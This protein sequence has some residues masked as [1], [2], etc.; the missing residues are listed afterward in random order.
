MLC[1]L[2]GVV[3]RLAISVFIAFMFVER[4]S[5]E[6]CDNPAAQGRMLRSLSSCY[7]FQDRGLLPQGKDK[8]KKD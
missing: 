1:V 4:Y 6:N 5:Q 2:L 8:K 3:W 7:R